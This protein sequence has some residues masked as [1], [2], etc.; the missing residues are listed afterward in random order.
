VKED[1]YTR[2]IHSSRDEGYNGGRE[3]TV[4]R[5]ERRAGRW[6]PGAVRSA[7]GPRPDSREEGKPKE[8]Q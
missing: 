2:Y 5:A 1:A 7:K 4:E 3:E 6:G 8:D